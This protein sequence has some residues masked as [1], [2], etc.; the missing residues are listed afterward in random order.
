MDESRSRTIVKAVSYRLFAAGAT[1]AIVF[2]FT[3]KLVLSIGVG[4]A[5]LIVKIIFFYLHERI[6][7]RVAW[8][9]PKHPL[10]DI[11]VKKELA[12]EDKKK[13]EEQLKSLGYL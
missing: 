11:P 6:W 2:A 8:G 10:S 13:V 5:E 9:K 4:I 3:R 12:P 7:G 1:T